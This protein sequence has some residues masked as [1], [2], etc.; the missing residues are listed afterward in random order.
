MGLGWA[1]AGGEEPPGCFRHAELEA[2]AGLEG[3]MVSGEL[4]MLTG[5]AGPAQPI[6]GSHVNEERGP[7]LPGG[8]GP[9]PGTPPA[10]SA[11]LPAPS[12]QHLQKRERRVLGRSETQSPRGWWPSQC[13]RGPTSVTWQKGQEVGSEDRGCNMLLKDHR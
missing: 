10:A 4:D 8:H 11:G 3:G 7:L 2:R 1:V 5:K 12:S 9:W 6:Q 13:C